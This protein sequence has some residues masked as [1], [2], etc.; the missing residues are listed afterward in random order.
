MRAQTITTTSRSN[1]PRRRLIALALGLCAL[2]IP[3]SAA[4]QPIDGPNSYV[5]EISGNADGS[6][7][8]SVNAIVPPESEPGT[9]S[10]D[11]GYSSVSAISGPVADTPTLAS[12]PAGDT[13]GFDWVS[14]LVGAGTALMLGAFGGVAVLT[15]R[16]RTVVSPSH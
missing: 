3:A 14:A 15:L 4:A 7:Y 10:T 11:S 2:A 8:S 9:G 6:D 16:R 12:A 5:N 1:Q 13:D